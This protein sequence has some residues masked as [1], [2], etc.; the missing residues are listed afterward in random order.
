MLSFADKFPC[1][2]TPALRSILPFG[3][4]KPRP[5]VRLGSRARSAAVEF[6]FF[7]LPGKRHQHPALNGR[8]IPKGTPLPPIPP[9]N[10]NRLFFHHEC[11][12]WDG[13]SGN[14]RAGFSDVPRSPPSSLGF[15]PARPPDCPPSHLPPLI[16]KRFRLER[17]PKIS[18]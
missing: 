5:C 11:V 16:P 1:A 4:G 18:P 2:G 8:S 17:Q 6:A 10:P 9:V 15:P 13:S 14:E 3:A 7:G 12:P